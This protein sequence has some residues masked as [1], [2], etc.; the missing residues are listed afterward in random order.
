M[1][2]ALTALAWR[3]A[4]VAVVAMLMLILAANVVLPQPAT[5]PGVEPADA[6]T[7]PATHA[8]KGN[9]TPTAPREV[10]IYHVQGGQYY[11]KTK[12]ERCYATDDEA[13]QDGCRRSRR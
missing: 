10:C 8:I 12:P 13:R 3:G 5:R 4:V 9:F 7:C 11:V 2:L 1:V 6:W